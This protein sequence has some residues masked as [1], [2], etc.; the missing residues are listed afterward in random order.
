MMSCTAAGLMA[1]SMALILRAFSSYMTMATRKSGLPAADRAHHFEAA[2]VRA[3]QED[4]A[5]RRQAPPR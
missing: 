4:A 1:A 5:A 2:Q 3:H